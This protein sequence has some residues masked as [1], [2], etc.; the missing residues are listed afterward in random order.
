MISLTIHT[1]NCRAHLTADARDGPLRV[2]T[3][4]SASTGDSRP[5][6][7][8]AG[9]RIDAGDRSLKHKLCAIPICIGVLAPPC[10][11]SRL[12]RGLYC[13]G[14]RLTN[15]W[16]GSLRRLRYQVLIGSKASSRIMRTRCSQIGGQVGQ[17]M[18][19]RV[20]TRSPNRRVAHAPNDL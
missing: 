6:P 9:C 10:S 13:L 7:D 4:R 11:F 20:A 2:E 5:K 12:R 15:H 19:K 16:R 14:L 3:G 1:D 18:I 8:L 17:A